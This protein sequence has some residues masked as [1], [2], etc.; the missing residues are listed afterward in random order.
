MAE[1]VRRADEVE[2]GFF[3]ARND[4]DGEAR[5]ALNLGDGFA[6]VLRVAQRGRR[7]SGDVRD[8]EAV[9]EGDEFS[10]NLDGLVDALLR[11]D[12]VLDVGREADDVLLFEQHVDVAAVDVVDGHADRARADVDDSMKHSVSPPVAPA[13]GTAYQFICRTGDPPRAPK[14]EGSLSEGAVSRMAD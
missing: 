7:E 6:A 11:H 3:V 5:A 13:E 14:K 10:K 9:Q 4:A 8:V 12:A 1:G 2:R